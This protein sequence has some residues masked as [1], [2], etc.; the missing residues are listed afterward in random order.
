MTLKEN[1]FCK[2]FK[3]DFGNLSA[4]I[5]IRSTRWRRVMVI[6]NETRSASIISNGD[7]CFTLSTKYHLKGMHYNRGYEFEFALS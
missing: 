7:P 5:F 6:N 4:H 2:A 1:I 3:R